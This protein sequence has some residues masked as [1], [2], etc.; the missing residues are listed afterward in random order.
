MAYNQEDR[1]RFTN[2]ALLD[3]FTLC[4]TG[5]R[6]QNHSVHLIGLIAPKPSNHRNVNSQLLN[7]LLAGIVSPLKGCPYMCAV[8]AIRVLTSIKL[9]KQLGEQFITSFKCKQELFFPLEIK[10]AITIQ[11][12]PTLP[13]LQWPAKDFFPTIHLGG[14]PVQIFPFPDPWKKRPLPKT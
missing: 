3:L 8:Q 6:A 14:D 4:S 2:L 5:G 12:N 11:K 7:H 1:A 10:E 13:S 9:Y